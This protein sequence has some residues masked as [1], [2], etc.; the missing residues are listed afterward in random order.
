MGP[1]VFRSVGCAN[2]HM[3]CE[4]SAEAIPFGFDLED[5]CRCVKFFR[6]RHEGNMFQYRP[7]V[8][9]F[10]STARGAL[11]VRCSNGSNSLR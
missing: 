4:C 9:M 8:F 1:V 3:N 10:I 11:M 6:V 2:A 5:G 7:A